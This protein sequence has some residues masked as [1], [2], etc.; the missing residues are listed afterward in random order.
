MATLILAE[1]TFR[2]KRELIR[3][4]ERALQQTN[5]ALARTLER[6]GATTVEHV[7]REID[8]DTPTLKHRVDGAWKNI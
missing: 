3:N 5:D 7:E 2:Q 1:L 4:A 6:C 8:G